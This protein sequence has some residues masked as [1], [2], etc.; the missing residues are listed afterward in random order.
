MQILTLLSPI[1]LT[2]V[3]GVA[4]ERGGFFAEG[5]MAG[6][7]KLTYWVGLPVLVF[8]SLATAE[9]GSEQAGPLLLGLVI[10]TTVSIG[11]AWVSARL[12]DV[13]A[14]GV[15]TW[16]QAAF[17]GNLTFIG[18]PIL[19]T[20]PGIPRT[21]AILTMAPLLVFYNGASVAML[22]ASR[23]PQA[24]RMSGLILREVVRNPIVVSSIVGGLF[25]LADWRLWVP[26][27]RA[28]SLV[29]RM[30]VPLALL[31]I[32]SAL[33]TTPLRGNRRLAVGAALF[34]TL[35]SPLIGYWVARSLGLE[36]G[37][38]RV[39]LLLM[40]CPTAAISYTMVRQLGGDHA[41]AAS[42]IV[43]STLFSIVSL[44][45]ILAVT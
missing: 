25:Y 16:M 40:A 10:A 21:A 22:L 1:L 23:N 13:K 4:L 2:I 5:F 33:V 45:V 7:N 15:G 39:V 35:V 36:A 17:R 27:E 26:L 9:H 18:L 43:V 42:S 37:E 44:A 6:V 3:L 14:D 12:L 34:K 29:S 11:L 41:I 19:L 28:I 8:Y 20:L 30:A 38:T 31:C 24:G 32:G